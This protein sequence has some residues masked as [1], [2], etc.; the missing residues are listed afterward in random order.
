MADFYLFDN[1]RWIMKGQGNYV[2]AAQNN[3][4]ISSGFVTLDGP[5]TTIRLANFDNTSGNINTVRNFD[6]SSINYDLPV[7]FI[8]LHFFCHHQVDMIS[9]N[10][11]HLFSVL[12]GVW[13]QKIS[14]SLM[15]YGGSIL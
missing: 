11:S 1:T 12:F 13:S 14:L 4:S 2:N 8:R 3:H 10:I 15:S 7:R 5:V 6:L 9:R